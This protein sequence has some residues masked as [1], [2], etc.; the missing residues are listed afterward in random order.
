MSQIS[1][2]QQTKLDAR[3]NHIRQ[4]AMRRIHYLA[5]SLSPQLALAVRSLDSHR[6]STPG[7]DDHGTI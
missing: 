1:Q 6:E 3:E 7:M 4:V 2:G 5:A